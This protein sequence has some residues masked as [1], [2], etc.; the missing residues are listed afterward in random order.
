MY[1]GSVDMP[2][3][4]LARLGYIMEDLY[5]DSIVLAEWNLAHLLEELAYSCIMGTGIP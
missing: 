2:S 1:L 5:R 4:L 3:D